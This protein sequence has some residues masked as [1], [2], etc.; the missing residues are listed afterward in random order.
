MALV[1]VAP[2]NASVD[3]PANPPPGNWIDTV[4]NNTMLYR[5]FKM[6]GLHGTYSP[7]EAQFKLFIDG[8]TDVG[9]A[10]QIEIAY[11]FDGDSVEDLSV[12]YKYWPLNDVV[13]YETYTQNQGVAKFTGAF[14]DLQGGSVIVRIWKAFQPMASSKATYQE[15]TS[16][17]EVPYTLGP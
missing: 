7:G 17:I 2:A 10:V 3:I 6:T 1:A 5:E 9:Q 14:A 13:G 15:G 11:D 12:I 8:G 4:P 16:F